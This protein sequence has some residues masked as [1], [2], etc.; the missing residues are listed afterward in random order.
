[1]TGSRTVQLSYR[2]PLS[3]RKKINKLPKKG[4]KLLTK[5]RNLRELRYRQASVSVTNTFLIKILSN[6]NKRTHYVYKLEKT[7]YQ[8]LV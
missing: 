8:Y 2:C 7:T 6:V 3:M 4:K 1:M 5:K